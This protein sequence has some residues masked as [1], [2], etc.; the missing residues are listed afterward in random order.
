[1]NPIRSKLAIFLT[2]QAKTGLKEI[3]KD[4][5]YAKDLKRLDVNSIL[6]EDIKKITGEVSFK[7]ATSIFAL[8]SKIKTAPLD[9]KG[10]IKKDI[11]EISKN[12]VARVEKK[13]GKLKT[14]KEFRDLLLNL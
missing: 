1:M 3:K 5:T 4:P 11:K 13:L 12:V 7:E 10:E 8:V 9:K 6:E 2:E 14:P